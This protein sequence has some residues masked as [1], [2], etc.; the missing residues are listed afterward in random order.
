M[1]LFYPMAEA[2][3][4]HSKPLI[5]TGSKDMARTIT[6]LLIA[7]VLCVAPSLAQ[8]EKGDVELGLQGQAFTAVGSDID[9]SFVN[10]VAKVGLY[11]TNSFE[12]GVSPTLSVITVEK[13][14]TTTLGS[15]VFVLYSFLAGDARTVPYAGA[16]Y[17][18]PDFDDTD[19]NAAGVTVGAKFFFTKKA[20]FDINGNYLFSLGENAEGGLLL[21]GFGLSYIL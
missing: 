16:Q 9:F 21:F 12:F 6:C 4:T 19:Q 2:H 18:I 13:N 17:Y 3:T 10:L 14:T 5:I 8:Q 11:A 15:G 7:T 20:A 1:Y